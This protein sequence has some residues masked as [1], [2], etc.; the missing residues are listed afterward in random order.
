MF[1]KLITAFLAGVFFTFILDFFFILGIFLHYIQALEIDVY[2]NV[3]FA[4]HQ[5]IFLFLTGV[6]IFGFLFIFV[7][8][9]KIAAIVFA[10]SFLLVCLT[11]LPSIGKEVGTMV[12]QEDNKIIKEGKE[13]F[14]GYIVYKGRTK[15][16]FFDDELNKMVIL[17]DLTH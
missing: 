6:V 5:N 4:D 10:I 8:N 15:I 16:W 17:S 12:L 7:D 1:I 13:T 2:Y 14:I 3:L 9:V 11:L